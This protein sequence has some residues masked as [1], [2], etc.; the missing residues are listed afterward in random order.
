MDITPGWPISAIAVAVV[1]VGAA[2]MLV[3]GRFLLMVLARAGATAMMSI[4]GQRPVR[5]RSG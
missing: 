5:G 3:L 4:R 1:G 2:T